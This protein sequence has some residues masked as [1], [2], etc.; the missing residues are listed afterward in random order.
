MQGDAVCGKEG[1]AGKEKRAVF[2]EY[3]WR[4]Q[5]WGAEMFRDIVSE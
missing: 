2:S 3:K 4:L 5:E 1:W